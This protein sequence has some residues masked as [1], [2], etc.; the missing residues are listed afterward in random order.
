[1]VKKSIKA[2][3]KAKK[4]PAKKAVKSVPKKATA[5]KASPQKP[6]LKVKAAKVK[7]AKTQTSPKKTPLKVKATK[8]QTKVKKT[9]PKKVPPKKVSPKKPAHKKRAAKGF[10]INELIVYPAHGVGQIVEISEQVIAQET[11]ELYII[12]FEKEKMTLNVPVEK[13]KQNGMRKLA[14]KA[15]MEGS[16]RTL[17]GRARVKRTMWSRR[18]Q[19]YEAKINSGG[20][21]A[22]SE[23]VRDLYRN[24]T[25]PEQSYSERQLYEAALERLA[26]EVAA[27][28]KS[29]DDEAKIKLE[30]LLNQATSKTDKRSEDL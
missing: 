23:V 19:E 29:T 4:T 30:A 6:P 11:L 18:A 25:Q 27:V 17:Q 28:E 26:R 21:I 24:E 3:S 1:M 10:R 7:A 8:T 14:D 12:Y 20:L 16:M 22:V 5:K 9:S 15:M 2:A 13:T